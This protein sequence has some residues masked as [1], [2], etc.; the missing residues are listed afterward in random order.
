M[1]RAE[2]C[3]ARFCEYPRA[4]S[5]VG[6][7]HLTNMSYPCDNNDTVQKFSSFILF[8]FQCAIY[9]VRGHEDERLGFIK[10]DINDERSQASYA[11]A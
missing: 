9:N 7:F 3:V 1:L 2:K 6:Y 11:Y 8:G 5:F 10:E 4:Y